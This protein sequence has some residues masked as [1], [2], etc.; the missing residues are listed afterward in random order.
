MGIVFLT[1]SNMSEAF[2]L[3]TNKILINDTY[4]IIILKC[5]HGFFHRKLILV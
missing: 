3:L 4:L 5:N 1:N 2:F